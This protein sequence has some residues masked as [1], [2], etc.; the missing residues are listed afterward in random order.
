MSRIALI[1]ATLLASLVPVAEGEQLY[2]SVDDCIESSTD[3]VTLPVTVPYR[4]SVQPCPT[5]KSL[6]LAVDASTRFFV[7]EQAVTLAE[8]RA[9]A[10]RRVHMMV[11]CRA[12]GTDRLTRIVL[13]GKL[14]AARPPSTRPVR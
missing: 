10:A 7:S 5:C 8:L 2:R 11:V 3:I 4:M 6:Q 12:T 9:Q 13:A 14:D 1:V